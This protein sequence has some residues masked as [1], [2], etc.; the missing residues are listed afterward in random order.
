MAAVTIR[1]EEE[2]LLDAQIRVRR[3]Q[4][5]LDITR[6]VALGGA[7]FLFLSSIAL[8]FLRQYNQLLAYAVLL[9]PLVITARL[10][11]FF[12][13]RHRATIGMYLF[14]ISVLLFAAPLPFLLPTV[15]PVVVMS[16]VMIVMLGNLVLGDKVNRWLPWICT[17]ALVADIIL[18]RDWTFIWFTPL[19]ETIGLAIGVFFSAVALPVVAWVIRLV[20]SEQFRESLRA[21]LEIERRAATE[22]QQREFLERLIIQIR[23]TAGELSSAA[24]EILATASQQ[25]AG[26]NEQV[27][28]VSETTSTIQEVRQTAEQSAE[29]ANLVSEMMQNSTSVAS[30][31]LRAVE[32]TVIGVNSV[33]EQVAAIAET[34]LSL[35]EQTQQIGEIIATVNDI[36]DQSNLLALNAAIEAAR[37]GEAGK[38]F[39]VVAGQVRSLAEQSRQATE[40]VREILGE[41][42]RVA[43]MAVMVTEEGAKRADAGV[44]QARAAGEAIQIISQDV[45]KV[46]QAAQQIAVSGKEQLAGM[47]Q[48]AAAMDSVNQA[49]AQS[50]AGT[51]QLEQ[52]A[53]GLNTLAIQLTQIVEQ[54]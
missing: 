5:A 38:G 11:P 50:Q 51:Q 29:R 9:L 41:I 36:A 52:A 24:A 47:D 17:L 19:D 25:A 49:S 43:N 35:S 37:A 33:K 26:A 54:Y 14:V 8:L 22:Q 15:M 10:Y 12:H 27:A 1:P 45:E 3:V 21:Y 2:K 31:G 23:D 20:V 4:L 46:A 40:Q 30:Q 34:I 53:Q 18:V 13:G 39:A 7:V 16:Y 6:Y 48:I 42:Q 32:G 28:A 44:T